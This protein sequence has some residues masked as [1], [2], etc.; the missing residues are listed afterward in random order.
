MTISRMTIAGVAALSLTAMA[1][2]PALGQEKLVTT[3]AAVRTVLAF[4]V[5]EAT[6][7]GLLPAGW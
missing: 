5:S 7:H 4:K 1:A 2:Y 3:D 6:L